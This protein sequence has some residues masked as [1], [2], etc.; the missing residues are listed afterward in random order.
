MD[1][2]RVAHMP[3]VGKQMRDLVKKAT[4]LGIKAEL[5]AAYEYLDQQLQSSPLTLRN[6][7][8]RTKKQGGVV[9]V[10]VIEPISV[11]FAVFETEKVVF[12]L[13]VNPLTW[14]FPR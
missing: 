4:Q 9:C 5:I 6:P 8:H 10:G 14:F 11:R 2:Y 3:Y 7:M 13:D 1:P 12:L